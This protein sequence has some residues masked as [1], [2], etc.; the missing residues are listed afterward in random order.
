MLVAPTF[1]A[2]TDAAVFYEAFESIE[3]YD[4]ALAFA[5][6]HKFLLWSNSELHVFAASDAGVCLFIFCFAWTDPRSQ[7]S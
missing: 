4:A 7:N 6:H 2:L 5:R 3:L 1:L